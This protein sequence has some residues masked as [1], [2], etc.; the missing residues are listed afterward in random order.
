MIGCQGTSGND[1]SSSSFISLDQPRLSESF[2]QSPPYTLL[3]H[4]IMV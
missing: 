3:K 1:F 4:F 2:P